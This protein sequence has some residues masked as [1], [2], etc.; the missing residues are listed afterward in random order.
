MYWE[1]KQAEP[2]HLNHWSG[3]PHKAFLRLPLGEA[4]DNSSHYIWTLCIQWLHNSANFIPQTQ[5]DIRSEMTCHF[6][7]SL[8]N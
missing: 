5:K 1:V 6:K 3:F 4:S 8:Q 7:F 2:I